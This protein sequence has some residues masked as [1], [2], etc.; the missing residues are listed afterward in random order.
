MIR[1]MNGRGDD[2]ECACRYMSVKPM[3]EV[4]EMFAR[5]NPTGVPK[6]MPLTVTRWQRFCRFVR[7]LRIDLR[8]PKG[9][10]K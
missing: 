8:T 5:I 2:R 7:D 6:A 3:F 10:T 1:E 4:N 9:K